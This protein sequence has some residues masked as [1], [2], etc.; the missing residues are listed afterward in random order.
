MKK[1]TKGAL[2]AVAATLSV[3]VIALGQGQGQSAHTMAQSA[4]HQ[5]K[6]A[7]KAIDLQETGSTLLWPLFQLWVPAYKHVASNVFL[8][9][10]GTGSGVGIA[11]A[12]QGVVQIG[13]S[14]AYMSSGQ[15]AQTP[16]MLNIPLA[17]SA[18]QIMYKIPGIKAS[19]H[20]HLTGNV[21]ALM[22][23]GKIKY[24]NAPQ[25]QRLN[26]GLKLPHLAIVPIHRHDGSGDTFLFTQFMTDT[27]AAWANPTTGVGYGTSVSWPAVPGALDG[28]GNSGVVQIAARTPGSIAYVGISWLNNALKDGMGEAMLQNRA[29]RFLLPDHAT[30]SAAA[31]KMTAKTP[32]DERISLIYA[33][34]PNS[35]P[36]INYEYAI[37]K[38]T[39][40]NV[41]TASA[42]KNLLL[43]AISPKGGNQAS[44]MG[45]VHFL[46]LPASIFPLSKAQ[47]EKIH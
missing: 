8:T 25:V 10:S 42:V 38:E 3:S 23:M 14:D 39:Q 20:L 28:V 15:L 46:P 11:E 40:A 1:T 44:F 12:T 35:Y 45:Q 2:L 37:V 41:Q 22:Y 34:G 5:A 33:P 24:W 26:K 43:W 19:T 18:Q 17:I 7:S 47:I 6:S 32:R 21:I 27:N 30:I 31:D 13:A 29:G 16:G 9:P 36:I 4:A